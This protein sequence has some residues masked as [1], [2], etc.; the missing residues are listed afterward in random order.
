MISTCPRLPFFG[1]AVA[2]GGGGGDASGSTALQ[3]RQ[4]VSRGQSAL[5]K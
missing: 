4:A 3:R 2:G 5:Q 1:R